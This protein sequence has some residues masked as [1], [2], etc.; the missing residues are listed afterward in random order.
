[1]AKPIN[2]GLPDYHKQTT[3][4][5]V[6]CLKIRVNDKPSIFMPVKIAPVQMWLCGTVALFVCFVLPGNPTI[7]AKPINAGLPDYHKQ[8]TKRI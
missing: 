8:T 2:A 1:M 7:M 4:R 5:I 3:K 6:V